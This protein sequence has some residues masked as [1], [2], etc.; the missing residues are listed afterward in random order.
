MLTGEQI[1]M[2][3][4]DGLGS[5]QQPQPLQR[6]PGEPVEQGGQQRPVGGL[7]PD[8]LVAELALQ[9]RELVTK[10]EDFGVLI[11]VAAGAVAEAA[12]PCS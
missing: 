9:H 7:E 5:D 6:G 4:Q 10:H 3:A 11:V 2:P 8:P 12:R 1:S